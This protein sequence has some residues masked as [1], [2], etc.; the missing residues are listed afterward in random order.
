VDP[1]R[2]DHAEEF[3]ITQANVEEMKTKRP[4]PK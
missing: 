1:Q 2:D 4:N 3:G